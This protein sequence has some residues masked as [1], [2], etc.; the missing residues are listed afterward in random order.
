MTYDVYF[1]VNMG[2]I[3]N[4]AHSFAWF[5]S[6]VIVLLLG[7]GIA[8]YKFLHAPWSILFMILAGKLRITN[9]YNSLTNCMF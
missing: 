1:S 2:S 8:I 5:A 3:P 6:D 7:S 9:K 4:I